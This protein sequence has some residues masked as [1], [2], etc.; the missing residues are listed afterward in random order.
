MNQQPT[1]YLETT[2]PSY[3]TSRSSNNLILAGEQEATHQWWQT[4][5]DCFNVFISNL[6]IQEIT[7]GD[8]FAAQRRLEVCEGISLLE[9]DDEAIHLTQVLLDSGLFPPKASTDAGH[10]AVAAR[11]SMDYLLTWNC[12]HIANAEIIR[13]LNFVIY[14]AGYYVPFICTPLELFGGEQYE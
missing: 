4:R 12:K 5:K 7:K 13:K 10:I 1:V 3:L 14:Q 8:V 11:H 6:V 2:I 9:I